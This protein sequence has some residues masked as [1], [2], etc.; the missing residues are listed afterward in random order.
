MNVDPTLHDIK[1]IQKKAPEAPKPKTE[2]AAK[3]PKRGIRFPGRLVGPLFILSLA[4]L[5]LLISVFSVDSLSRGGAG[6]GSFG[7]L[8]DLIVAFTSINADINKLRTEGLNFAFNG[9][10]EELIT[11]LKS[12]RTNLGKLDVLRI[13]FLNDSALNTANEGLDALITFLDKPG[14]QHLLVLFLNPSEM[15]P[16]GGF[17]GSYGELVLER[18]N[19]KEI[20]VNDIYYPD[21][22]LNKKIVPP[23]ELQSVTVDWGARDAAWFF[24][25][26]T[27]AQKTME[28]LEASDIYVKDGVRFDGV[29]A[30]NVRIVE[31]I[32]AL[33][34]PIK[35]PEYNLTLTEDNFLEEIQREVEVGHDKQAGENPKRVLNALTPILIERLQALDS[36]DKNALMLTLLGRAVNKDIQFYF[37]DPKAEGFVKKVG[38]AGEMAVLDAN[39]SGDYL[40]VVNTNVAGGKTDAR[41]EQTIK[42]KSEID[43]DG[44]V[45][46]HLTIIRRHNGKANDAPW[47]QAKNQN[48]IKIF[49]PPKAELISLTGATAKTINPRINYSVSGYALDPLLVAIEQTRKRVVK[50][51]TVIYSESGKTVFGAWSS[52]LAGEARTLEVNYKSGE[53]RLADSVKYR[54]ILDKQSGVESQFEY[55]VRAPA[56]YKW[57]ES[58]GSTFAYQSDTIPARLT[59]E[60][61]LVRN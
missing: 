13:G 7:N 34:G 27:S 35:L 23:K 31:D 48:F 2:K 11:T 15:R 14:E 26:P 12:L 21:K 47:Y 3:Q 61:T 59:I 5:V 6:Q 18:G 8:K 54:F 51:S 1:P 10:G 39:L 42:L 33:T 50:Y 38:W 44:R 4:A 30:V 55:E 9:R 60:L 29:V 19:I 58:N 56:G 37:E 43:T 28:L 16:I 53:I 36:S 46:N 17:A 40:A 22:F 52:I 25:F 32:L 41:I 20:K 24:D 57:A 49:T 45:N